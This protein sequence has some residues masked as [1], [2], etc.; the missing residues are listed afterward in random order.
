MKDKSE[1]AVPI[2]DLVNLGKLCEFLQKFTGK[3]IRIHDQCGPIEDVGSAFIWE[4]DEKLVQIDIISNGEWEYFAKDRKTGEF[5]GGEEIQM[6][7]VPPDF[8]KVFSEKFWD[9]LA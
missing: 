5:G 4:K 3:P 9:V 1:V 8:E 6:G 7:E 2:K